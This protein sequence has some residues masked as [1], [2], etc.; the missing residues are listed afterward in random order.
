MKYITL[1]ATLVGDT[2]LSFYL[3]MEEYVARNIDEPDCFFMWQ[4]GPT[5]IFGRNQVMQNEVNTAYCREHGIEMFRRKSGGGCVYADRENIMLSFITKS[6]NVPLT[7]NRFMTMLIFVLRKLGL[8]AVGTAHNDVLIG[9]RKVCGTAF[10]QLPGHS[11]VHSTMLYG[12]NMEHMLNAITPSEE[13]LKKKGI[14]SVRQRITFLK[15]YID[16]NVEEVK[17][18]IR[19]TLCDGELRLTET[20]VEGIRRIEQGYLDKE[21][22]QRL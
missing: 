7:F 16:L 9:D 15:E 14:E 1:P 20:D 4:V 22:I 8:E 10:Y 2:H 11:I 12:T 19:R 5:V 3:A 18:F 6:D 21:F 17:A 13:K